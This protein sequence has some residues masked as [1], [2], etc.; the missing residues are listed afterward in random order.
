MVDVLL[1]PQE[2]TCSAQAGAAQRHLSRARP[3][4]RT[5]LQC[6]VC[7]L[8]NSAMSTRHFLS[9]SGGELSQVTW[10]DRPGCRWSPHVQAT[11]PPSRR[12]LAPQHS[13]RRIS[14]PLEVLDMPCVSFARNW[15]HCWPADTPAV[16][17]VLHRCS[18]L[19]KFLTCP[20][21]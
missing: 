11:P 10:R 8:A 2:L 14:Q 6:T 21:L 19:F 15:A 4:T 1:L 12:R 20:R 9:V 18:R 7:A 3:T 17:G 5:S 13:E 16:P